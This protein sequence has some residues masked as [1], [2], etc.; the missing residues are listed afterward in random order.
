[1]QLKPD[2][3]PEMIEG[4]I[5]RVTCKLNGAVGVNTIDTAEATSSNLT[6]GLPSISGTDISFLLTASQPGTYYVLVACTLSSSET[7]KGRFRVNV[8]A[9]TCETSDDYR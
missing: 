3:V 2:D 8:Q 1:M 9:E 5:R 6:L 4:E 7:I